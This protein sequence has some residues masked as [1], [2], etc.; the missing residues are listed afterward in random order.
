MYL[1]GSTRQ[2]FKRPDLFG[3]MF[4]TAQRCGKQ[5]EALEAS[6][7][8][9]IDNGIFSNLWQERE[10]LIALYDFLKFRENC[11]GCII[12]DFLHYLPNKQ[13]RGDWQKTLE[14]FY[15]YQPVVKRLSFPVAL[16]SQDGM[17]LEEVPWHM[18][19]VL[20]IGGSNDHKRGIEAETLAL[21]AKKRG[22][23]VHVGRVSSVSKMRKLWSWADSWD[24]TT[25]R[26]Q[27]DKKEE[28]LVPQIEK[29]FQD[30]DR[31]RLHQYKLL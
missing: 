8:F 17:P 10:W 26:F 30:K 19:D 13:V 5:Q 21:E 27:P 11:L 29:F 22:K 20:F 28:S 12:P 24:G 25:F 9:M 16:A 7:K 23:W 15:L 2:F 18:F 3:V 14:R 6:C 1:S 31:M 4:N